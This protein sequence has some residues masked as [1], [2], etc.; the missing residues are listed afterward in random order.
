MASRRRS[1]RRL[2]SGK[3]RYR[4][5]L[6][7]QR[8]PSSPR[9]EEALRHALEPR[10]GLSTD[11]R[12]GLLRPPRRL[13]RL[14]ATVRSPGHRLRL[15][16]D[17][18]GDSGDVRDVTESRGRWPP[19]IALHSRVLRRHED[20][21]WVVVCSLRSPLDKSRSPWYYPR[22]YQRLSAR[23]VRGT[24]LLV[25]GRVEEYSGTPGAVH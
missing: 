17:P 25:R 3:H 4:S 11:R 16:A 18:D 19:S 6:R 1:R 8:Q 23:L 20:A 13:L 15:P 21:D 10:P 24:G 12:E 14:H 9:S 22:R 5:H 7:R 2:C